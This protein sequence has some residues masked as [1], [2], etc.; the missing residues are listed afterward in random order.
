MQ[1]HYNLMY[2]EEEREMIPLCQ[3]QG[4]GLIPWSPLARG[5]L[6]GNTQQVTTRTK[7]DDFSKRL[8]THPSNAKII[9]R[10][11]EV[12]AQRGV[13]PA[14][15]ALAWILSKPHISSPIVG[16]SKPHHLGDALAALELSL[17]AEEI[18]RLEEVYEPH[19]VIGHG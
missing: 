2:R 7:T 16:A 6:A 11:A 8:Y 19:P 5:Q 3:D 10:V 12:A 15:V 18:K 4:I 1:N 13:P 9:E 14:Q 17:D